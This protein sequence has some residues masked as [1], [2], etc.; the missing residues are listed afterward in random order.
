VHLKTR[1]SGLIAQIASSKKGGGKVIVGYSKGTR[2]VGVRIILYV[3]QANER[4]GCRR[5]RAILSKEEREKKTVSL[6][7]R[8]PR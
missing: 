4:W 8:T 3:A 1:E 7:M 2:F 5:R 6:S